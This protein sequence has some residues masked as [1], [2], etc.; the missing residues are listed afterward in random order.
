MTVRRGNLE[1]FEVWSW[2]RLDV[3]GTGMNLPTNGDRTR[4]LPPGLRDQFQRAFGG[5][6]S[7]G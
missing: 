4:N 7:G 1:V 3:A 5:A 2:G 6:A